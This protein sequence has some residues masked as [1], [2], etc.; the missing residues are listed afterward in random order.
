MPH[1]GLVWLP[2]YFFTLIAAYKYGLAVGLLTAI[3]S[4]LA[5]SAFFGMPPVAMLPVIGIKSV[6]LAASAAFIARKA[7]RVTLSGL[8][9][10]V[11][12]YQLVG[13]GIEALLYGSIGAGLQD[14]RLGWPGMLTQVLGGYV[15]LKYL[16]KK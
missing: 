9:A 4:P 10:A 11:A 14:W 15:V 8:A 5:N 1:G 2:I 12:A 6:L 7:S 3:A 13:G 16:L